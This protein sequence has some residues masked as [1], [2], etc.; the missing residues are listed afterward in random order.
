[1][2]CYDYWRADFIA[3]VYQEQNYSEFD[4]QDIELLLTTIDDKLAITL[5]SNDC[6]DDNNNS[7]NVE[8]G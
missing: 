4:V 1:M 7:G 6:S 8:I 5:P 3:R 2:L